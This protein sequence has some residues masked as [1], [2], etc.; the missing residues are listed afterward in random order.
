MKVTLRKKK[1]KGEKSSLYLD[2]T[3][4]N[5]RKKEYLKLVFHENPRNEMER[6][7]NKHNMD[8]ARAIQAKRLVE[9]KEGKFGFRKQKTEKVKFLDYYKLLL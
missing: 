6:K 9:L 8:L 7:E 4:E 3:M 1:L 2:I 5:L